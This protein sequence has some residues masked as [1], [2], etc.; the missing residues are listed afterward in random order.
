MVLFASHS[1]YLGHHG[2]IPAVAPGC[3]FGKEE[4]KMTEDDVTS[5]SEESPAKK[6]V[7]PSTLVAIHAEV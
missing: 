4:F 7:I 1:H 3:L 6:P 2:K 5:E